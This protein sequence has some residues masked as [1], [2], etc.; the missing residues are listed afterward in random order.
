MRPNANRRQ[1]IGGKRYPQYASEQYHHTEAKDTEKVA[2]S[3]RRLEH[4]PQITKH[5]CDP[6]GDGSGK[7]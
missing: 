2:W 7:Q 1:V 4:A 6:L 3:L 5:V